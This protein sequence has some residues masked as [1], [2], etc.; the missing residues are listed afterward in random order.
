MRHRVRNQSLP[1]HVRH[2]REGSDR[3]PGLRRVRDDLLAARIRS[4]QQAGRRHAARPRHDSCGAEVAPQHL[5]QQQVGGVETGGEQPQR[6]ADQRLAPDLEI[7]AQQHARAAERR[8]RAEREGPSQAL[9]QPEVAGRRH[10]DECQVG[11]QRGVGQRRVLERLVPRRQVAGEGSAGQPQQ[12]RPSPAAGGPA[13]AVSR[14]Q[15]PEE[16]R[17]QGSAPERRRNHAEAAA[18]KVLFGVEGEL[19]EDRR[20]ADAAQRR[21]PVRSGPAAAQTRLDGAGASHPPPA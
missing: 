3:Q 14:V 5:H 20:E 1:A 7:D 9:P 13:A 4:G 19:G 21:T 15:P 16:R 6:V 8:R 2:Q 18:R 17:G 12:R 11:E 10:Q